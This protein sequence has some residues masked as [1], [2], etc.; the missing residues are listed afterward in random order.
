VIGN[1]YV[2]PGIGLGTILSK[3]TRVTDNMIY[4]SGAALPE[5]L[6]S[7]EAGM[8]LLYPAV[9]RIRH[10]SVRV[11]RGVIRT[12]Q[13]DGVARVSKLKEMDDDALDKWI[14]ENMYDPFTQQ[15][16]DQ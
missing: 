14:I 16:R 7:E 2:F 6:T 5:M 4:A 13:Q 11:A 12:A 8:G 3:A 15:G 10:V 1:R 9:D